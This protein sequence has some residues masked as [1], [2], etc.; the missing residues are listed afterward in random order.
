VLLHKLLAPITLPVFIIT[1][2]TTAI[3]G[4][5]DQ[6]EGRKGA[7]KGYIRVEGRRPVGRHSGRWLD[8]A[9]RDGKEGDETQEMERVAEGGSAWRRRIEEVEA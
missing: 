8:A 5:S 1:Y 2:V 9:D 6:D 7:L 4:S 3:S